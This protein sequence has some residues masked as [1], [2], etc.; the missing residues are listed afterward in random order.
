MSATPSA[1]AGTRDPA[2]DALRVIA[3]LAC[4]GLHSVIPYTSREIGDLAWAVRDTTRSV[5]ADFLFWWGRAAQAQT[6]FFIAGVLSVRM[7]SVTGA[8]G[9]ARA[10]LQRLGVPFAAA[11]AFVLP[12]VAA[13]WA[14]GWVAS[15]RA[16]WAEV[17]AWRFSDPV[18]QRNALGPAHLWFLQDLLIISVGVCARRAPRALAQ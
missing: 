17:W 7:M 2:I 12:I 15:G 16:T 8:R 5:A 14:W 1:P 13:V 11:V 10:R 4:I 18:V 6:F 3:A 9:Y